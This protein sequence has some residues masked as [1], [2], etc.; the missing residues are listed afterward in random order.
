MQIPFKFILQFGWGANILQAKTKQ[1]KVK[2]LQ[3]R[4]NSDSSWN[5]FF[6]LLFVAVVII[7][8]H[9]GLPQRILPLCL[10][11]K[12]KCFCSAQREIIWTCLPVNSYNKEKRWTHPFQRLAISGDVFQDWRSFHCTSPLPLPL[13]PLTSSLLF[14]LYSSVF[15]TLV[16]YCPSLWFYKRAWFPDPNKMVTLRH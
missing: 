6:G 1:K 3:R 16:P 11:V 5:C 13:F 8:T 7:I 9:N 4:T 15:L 12:L 10:T 2:S 14:P